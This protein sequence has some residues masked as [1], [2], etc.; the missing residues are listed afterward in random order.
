M[1]FKKLFYLGQSS[2]YG[3][4]PRYKLSVQDSYPSPRRQQV[5][6]CLSI[7]LSIYLS[8]CIY[9]YLLFKTIY[10]PINLP[11]YLFIFF[12]NDILHI[13]YLSWISCYNN[14]RLY[15]KSKYYYLC[16]SNWKEQD[17]WFLIGT[18]KTALVQIRINYHYKEALIAG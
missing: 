14:I 8:I 7:Y 10:L 17:A 9:F 6:R 16:S 3:G 11:I 5:P 4:Q 15:I 12:Q 1:N 13:S 18:V 2:T